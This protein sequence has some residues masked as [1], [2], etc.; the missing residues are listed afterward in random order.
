[1]KIYFAASIRGGRDQA[2]RYPA[3]V[4]ILKDQGHEIL[5]ELFTDGKLTKEGTNPDKTSQWIY[6]R[7]IDW[8]KQSHVVVAEVTQ[9]SLG[10]GYE[11]AKAEEWGKTVICLF[12]DMGDKKLS[13]MIDGTASSKVIYYKQ[14]S[15]LE[16]TLAKLLQ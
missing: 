8:I 13:A 3:I 9:P 11:I 6:Q 15:E 1:M 14:V 5:S 16:Q 2:D 7:D 10:V 12:H 4:Q